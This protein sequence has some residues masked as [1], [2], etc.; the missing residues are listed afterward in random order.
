MACTA[1]LIFFWVLCDDWLDIFS[2]LFIEFSLFFLLSVSLILSKWIY[3]TQ[4]TEIL[5]KN[6]ILVFFR[7]VLPNLDMQFVDVWLSQWLQTR[8]FG[9]E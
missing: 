3:S 1:T 7:N 9:I 8:Q 4:E 2:D 6:V 5:D